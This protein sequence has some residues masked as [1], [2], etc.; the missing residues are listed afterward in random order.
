MGVGDM[1]LAYI[2]EIG[3]PGAFVSRDHARFNT[4][5][6]FGYAGFIIPA[7]KAR[8]LGARFTR[9]KRTLFSA[10]I[11][12]SSHPG[13]WER[14]GSELFRPRTLETFPQHVRAF[15]GL[16]AA[17]RSL[18][19]HLFYYADEKRLGTPKQTDLD[20]AARETA[21]MQEALNRIARHAQKSDANVLVMIDQINE[22]QRAERLPRMYS[23]ILGRAAEYPE[24]RR[25]VEPPMHVDSRLSSNIQLADWVAACVTRAIE[26]QLI[27][28]SPYKWVCT[29][30]QLGAMRGAFTNESKVHLWNRAIP[31][32]NHSEIY[33]A[34]R[35]VHPP[36]AGQLIGSLAPDRF[37]V[38]K[39]AAE[40]AAQHS[41]RTTR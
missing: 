17:V 6:A 28:T 1:H 31:D 29:C 30:K 14:K 7:D 39:A 21:A 22:N 34:D 12:A 23:H 5:P 35:A 15:G 33:R 16:V 2:D 32:L 27:D 20:I 10:E 37:R 40:R 11:E 19:G 13:R 18:G 4:S 38:I 9:T 26:Y 41:R 36:A 24:M 25:I 3:E 8:D